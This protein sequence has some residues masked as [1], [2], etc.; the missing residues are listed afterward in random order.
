M[1]KHLPKTPNS[2]DFLGH[3]NDAKAALISLLG[4]IVLNDPT[5]F[6]NPQQYVHDPDNNGKKALVIIHRI[7]YHLIWPLEERLIFNLL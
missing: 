5:N 1:K 4:S 6:C 3:W 2:F 7:S